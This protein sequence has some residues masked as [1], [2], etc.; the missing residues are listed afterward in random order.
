M[1]SRLPSWELLYYVLLPQF[2]SQEL[3]SNAAQTRAGPTD[4]V[5]VALCEESRECVCVRYP[6]G[7]KHHIFLC[8]LAAIRAVAR[9]SAFR[10]PRSRSKPPPPAKITRLSCS[11]AKQH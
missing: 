10:S 5:R 8:K 2:K 1:Q 3:E 6:Q 7:D 4:G 9:D 11:E